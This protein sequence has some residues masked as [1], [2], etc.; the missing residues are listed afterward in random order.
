MKKLL[1]IIKNTII[2]FLPP[3]ILFFVI[4]LFAPNQMLFANLW[5]ALLNAISATVLAVGVT[6]SFKSGNWDLAIGAE[7]IIAA[8][9]GGQLALKMNVGVIGLIIGCTLAGLIAGFA[10]GAV[11][12]VLK[13][14]SII[15]TLGMLLLFESLCTILFEGGGVIIPSEWVVLG[16]FPF[17]V[18]IGICACLL[19]YYILFHRKIGFH[20][21]A[22]G[23]NINLAH[24]NGLNVYKVKLA[25]FAF[26]GL[27]AGIYAFL[28]LGS[29]GVQKAPSNSMASLGIA[30]DAMMGM[31]LGTALSK[32]V[33]L[34]LGIYIGEVFMQLIKMALIIFNVSSSFKSVIIA[35]MVVVF[36]AVSARSDLFKKRKIIAWK[37]KRC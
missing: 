28:S 7:A 14:P 17:N 33:N 13:V 26:A 3:L 11:Y 4:K 30:F 6:F 37:G 16:R 20:L 36:M 25:S 27:F 1:R 2:A 5:L 21:N 12:R 19:A 18:I 34:I 35:V 24:F 9:V 32:R 10:T 31:F 22:V 29:N 8:I 15:V 23:D